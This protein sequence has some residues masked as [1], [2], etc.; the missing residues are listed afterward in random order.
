MFNL[1]AG[2]YY[3]SATELGCTKIDTFILSPSGIDVSGHATSAGCFGDSMGTVSV[4]VSP[5]TGSYHYF[6]SIPRPDTPVISGLAAGY[7]TVTIT[8][9]CV[10]D[11]AYY[12]VSQSPG[13]ILSLDSI[14]TKC[15]TNSGVVAVTNVAGS[16]TGGPWNYLWS[17]GKTTAGIDSLPSGTY[18]V[19]VTGPDGCTVTAR[20][21]VYATSGINLTIASNGSCSTTNDTA[22]VT[23]DTLY[24]HYQWST[25]DTTKVLVSPSTG[26]YR[27]TVTDANGCSA[28]ALD[29]VMT[30]YAC[31]FSP[32]DTGHINLINQDTLSSQDSIPPGSFIYVAAG[33][34]LTVNTNLTLQQCQF[35]MGSNSS[36]DVINGDTLKILGSTFKGCDSMWY[37]ITIEDT[38]SIIVAPYG[39]D[40]SSIAD[41]LIGITVDSFV[42]KM[43]V[44]STHFYRNYIA[45]FFNDYMATDSGGYQVANSYFG[46]GNNAMLPI[47]AVYHTHNLTHPYTGI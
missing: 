23:G 6:W 37:G 44:T 12:Q 18:W 16:L 25:G 15:G 1:S 22:I 28:T 40:T 31:C 38:S 32:P 5:D 9:G 34:T 36:I 43:L 20:D 13:L 29:T 4:A 41:A 39:G 45:L 11:T 10:Y 24:I 27:I 7:Y 26:T 17:N 46:L 8:G 3:V 47:P 35:V 33:V 19:T 42:V 30:G 2:H 14:P 21:S